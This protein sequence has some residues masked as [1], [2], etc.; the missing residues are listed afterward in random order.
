MGMLENFR[1]WTIDKLNPAQSSIFGKEPSAGPES[2]TDYEIAYEEIDVI[3]RAIEVIISAVVDIPFRVEGNGP[4]KKVSKLINKRPNPFEDRDKFYRRAILDLMLDGNIFFYYDGN[5]IYILPA[6]DVEIIPD[7]TTYIHHYEYL[8]SDPNDA[9]SQVFGR[10]PRTRES[11]RVMFNPDEIIHIKLDNQNSIY[12]G[13]SRLRSVDQLIKLYYELI[14]F[15]QQFFKNNAVPGVVLTSENVLSTKIKERLLQ[16]WK[17]THTTI[18]D[19]ARN[20]AILD[21]G[22]KIDKFSNINFREMDFENSVERLQ[23]DMSKA[24]GVPYVLLKS[25]NNA[26]ITQNQK[27]LYEHTILP[28]CNMIASSFEHFFG[29]DMNIE[30]DKLEVNALRPDAK[31]QAQYWATLVNTGI[32]TINEARE[33]LRLEC[34]VDGECDKLRVPQNITGS[35]TNPSLGGKPEGTSTTTPQSGDGKAISKRG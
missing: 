13:A 10:A 21:G 11:R 33:Q 9:V 19:G 5:H 12:R 1:L 20:P 30:P 26:N 8:I 24:I 15:Q 32:A 7:P 6:N 29:P 28:I 4:T 17:M 3:H 31:T 35:A 18:F 34:M 22:L 27:L 14:K 16:Q 2:I 23:Q 25:G